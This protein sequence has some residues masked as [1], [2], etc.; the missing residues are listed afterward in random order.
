MVSTTTKGSARTD[1]R[2]GVR[3][4]CEILTSTV[5]PETRGGRGTGRWTWVWRP[6]NESVGDGS[7]SA[8]G[9]TRE[10]DPDGSRGHE[11]PRG[12]RR[13]PGKGVVDRVSSSVLTRNP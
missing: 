13:D 7:H 5:R 10:G 11:E 2:A 9:D 12:R 6:R 3:T 8:S 1:E 4:H